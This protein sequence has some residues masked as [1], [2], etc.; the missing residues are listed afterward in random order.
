MYTVNLSSPCKTV[1]FVV[2]RHFAKAV[3]V[4]CKNGVNLRGV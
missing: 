1:N 4:L 3:P 2:L